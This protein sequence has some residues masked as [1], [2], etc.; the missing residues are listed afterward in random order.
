M[1]IRIGPP[2][3]HT[4]Q[5]KKPATS[6]ATSNDELFD[7]LLP[8]SWSPSKSQTEIHFPVGPVKN[9]L[10]QSLAHHKYWGVDGARIESTGREPGEFEL[11]IPLF[12]NIYP[13]R[14]EKWTAGTL[15]P[16]VFRALLGAFD[17]DKAGTLS[18]PELGTIFCRWV[19]FE[20]TLDPTQ[21]DGVEV[22]CRFI[23]SRED[24]DDTSLLSS[25]PT[26]ISKMKVAA[27][28][29]DASKSDLLSKVPEAETTEETFD[30]LV[31]KVTARIDSINEQTTKLLATP[32]QLSARARKVV[33]A[34][35][36]S[37]GTKAAAAW[38][39]KQEAEQID[40]AV[41]ELKKSETKTVYTGGTKKVVPAETQGR[42][43]CRYINT[44][45]DLT[46]SLLN[47]RL[48]RI[49]STTTCEELQ[50]LNPQ[51]LNNPTIP[52]NVVVRYYM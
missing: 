20:W 21:R 50:E 17:A 46:L 36:R 22:T 11:V 51:L 49:G 43:I 23:E 34:I 48:A 32:V 9:T 37:K 5:F 7:T 13:A 26:P 12:N 4:P 41:A 30:S 40:E 24:L 27:E 31:G 15:Y 28:N 2:P 33:D 6:S 8:A 3:K 39:Y 18:H 45:R 16:D 10:T 52:V 14:Q 29:L 47:S 44:E 1:S 25:K 35:N 38:K 19:S 42:K